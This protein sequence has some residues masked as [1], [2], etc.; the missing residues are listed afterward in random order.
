LSAGGFG[1]PGRQDGQGILPA[2]YQTVGTLW[3]LVAFGLDFYFKTY[4]DGYIPLPAGILYK[5]WTTADGFERY[6]HEIQAV[7]GDTSVLKIQLKPFSGYLTITG[8]IGAT[9]ANVFLDGQNIGTV[10][11]F[12]KEVRLGMHTLHFEKEGF[13]TDKEN[14]QIEIQRDTIMEFH[15]SMIT[16]NQYRFISEPTG[17]EI[18][19]NGERAGFT[20]SN[21]I[22]LKEGNNTV[23]IRKTGFMDY[24]KVFVPDNN[25]KEQTMLNVLL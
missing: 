7:R 12:R 8:S 19:V 20:P 10:P 3:L 13:L 15:S 9:G 24:K 11:L 6:T 4:K 14:Y 21:S 5:I 2:H 17:A 22:N 25:R 18:F 1:C 23:I 16:F